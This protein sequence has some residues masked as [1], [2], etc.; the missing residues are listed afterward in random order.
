MKIEKIILSIVALVVGLL[1]AGIAFYFFKITA[2]K[3]ADNSKTISILSPTP[4]PLPSTFLIVDKPKDEEV[5]TTKT[6]TVS[7]R[8]TADAVLV[9]VVNDQEDIIEPMSNG[10]F[11][12]TITLEDGQNII[13][14]SA[15]FSNGESKTIKKTVTVSTEEF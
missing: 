5:V 7:G 2:A 14:I 10:D 6:V 12:A 4:S 1:V 11:S 8:T 9:V 15:I 3:P 13:S